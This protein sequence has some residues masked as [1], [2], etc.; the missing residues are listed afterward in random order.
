MPTLSLSV[1]GV[2]NLPPVTLQLSPHINIFYGR[3]GR[4]KTSPFESV[5]FLAMARSFRSSKQQPMIQQ[6]ADEALV[7]A[8]IQQA[9]QHEPSRLGVSRNRNTELTIRLNGETLRSV[10]GLA[11]TLPL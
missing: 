9:Q 3:N 4:G 1:T 6:G 7:F 8:Q 11:K 10:S 2:R 5:Y